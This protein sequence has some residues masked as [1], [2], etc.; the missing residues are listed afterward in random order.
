MLVS[1]TEMAAAAQLPWPLGNARSGKLGSFP[2]LSPVRIIS[3]FYFASLPLGCG[4]P[5]QGQPQL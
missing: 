2:W 5:S 3:P 1:V 4:R